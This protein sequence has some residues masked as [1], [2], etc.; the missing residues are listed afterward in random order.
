MDKMISICG[1][2]FKD[3]KTSVLDALLAIYELEGIGGGAVL[4]EAGRTHYEIRHIFYFFFLIFFID[5]KDNMV[6]C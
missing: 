4:N 2:V 3:G 5:L 1:S 6:V